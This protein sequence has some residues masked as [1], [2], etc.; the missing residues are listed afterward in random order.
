M[1]GG[2]LPG[3]ERGLEGAAVGD[4]V[5]I[6]LESE[7]AYG[8]YLNEL[9]TTVN[10]DSF[11]GAELEVGVQLKLSTSDGETRLV[12]IHDISGDDVTIDANHPL[13]GQRVRYEVKVLAI[14]DATND[15]ITNR[16]PQSSN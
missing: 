4:E 16:P 15:E 14:L 11:D 12:T 5:D 1:Q 8:E 13:A 10:R 7:D 9:V 6:V 3:L 2:I